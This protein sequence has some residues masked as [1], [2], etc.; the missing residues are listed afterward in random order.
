MTSG[1]G[2]LPTKPNIVILLNDQDS[3]AVASRWPESFEQQHLPA[4]QRLKRNGI[5]FKYVESSS[6][7]QGRWLPSFL[8]R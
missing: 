1:I 8:E 3:A 4:M 7:A 6:H 2:S 5:N